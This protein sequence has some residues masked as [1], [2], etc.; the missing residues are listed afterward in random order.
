MVAA[1]L[2]LVA[3]IL[4]CPTELLRQGQLQPRQRQLQLR[5]R[6]RKLSEAEFKAEEAEK[7]RNRALT[8][9]RLA[10][11]AARN[12][13]KTVVDEDIGLPG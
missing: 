11:T 1:V 8:S 6:L 4:Y 5:K 9:I 3:T 13:V 12:L 7:Q 10:E 2:G